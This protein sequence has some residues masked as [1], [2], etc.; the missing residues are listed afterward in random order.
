MKQLGMEFRMKKI[1]PF[2]FKKHLILC[3]MSIRDKWITF[4]REMSHDK[5]TDFAYGWIR[6]S[7]LNDSVRLCQTE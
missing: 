1:C 3:L 4:I 6:N 7:H 2:L 5:Q